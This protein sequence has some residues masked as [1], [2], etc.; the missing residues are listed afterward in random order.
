MFTESSYRFESIIDHR[1]KM[2]RS[3]PGSADSTRFEPSDAQETFQRFGFLTMI[4]IVSLQSR[5]Q[6]SLDTKIVFIQLLDA[7]H[8]HILL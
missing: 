4:H 6:I 7:T 2:N 3:R 8:N 5:Y 1:R